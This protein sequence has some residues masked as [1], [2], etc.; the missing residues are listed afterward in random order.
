M[1]LV[2]DTNIIISAA[3]WGGNARQ[4]LEIAQSDHVLCFTD[5]TLAELER[6]LRYPKFAERLKNFDFTIT[7]FIER[8]TER[9]L[10]MPVSAKVIDIIKADPD[11]NKFLS[12]A[13]DAQADVIVSG[14]KHLLEL[15]TFEDIKIITAQELIQRFLSN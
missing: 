4:A 10:I 8:L 2:F 12:C 6:V 5:D 9:A 14:D 11:D 15:K 13:R 7:E 3:F 1:R